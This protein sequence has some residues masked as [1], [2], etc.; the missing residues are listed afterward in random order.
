[1]AQIPPFKHSFN[2]W[3]SSL[4]PHVLHGA[5]NVA[6]PAPH[7]CGDSQTCERRCETCAAIEYRADL[8]PCLGCFDPISRSYAHWVA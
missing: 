2:L 6:V 7:V 8:L 4:V 3:N 5:P 1:M